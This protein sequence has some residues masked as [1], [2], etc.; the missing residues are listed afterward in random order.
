MLLIKLFNSLSNK[1]ALNV[2][3]RYYSASIVVYLVIAAAV[4]K[5]MSLASFQVTA[6]Y[7]TTNPLLS[8]RSTSFAIASH[9]F[10]NIEFR[11][12]LVFLMG[13][14]LIVPAI[15]IYLIKN[16]FKKIDL[17]KYRFIDWAVTGSFLLLLVSVLSGIEDLASLVLIFA[18]SIV[19]Y[20]FF[21]TT[22]NNLEVGKSLKEIIYKTSIGASILPWLIIAFYALNTWVYGG[23]RSP[24]YVYAIYIVGL[25]NLVM[26][27][28]AYNRLKNQ[29]RAKSP[30]GHSVYPVL[31]NQIFRVS[32]CVILIIGLK[33]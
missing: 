15:Y 22:I 8:Q 19:S 25:L 17:V 13:L 20:A 14:S 23:I 1:K 11:W 31:I 10:W 3:F 33:R 18:L 7:L 32:F 24:W 27:L 21:W 4:I 5:F 12:I 6:P 26:V 29:T 2:I 30:S 28:Y 9:V 16:N